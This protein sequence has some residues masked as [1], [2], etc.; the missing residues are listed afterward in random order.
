[1]I[2]KRLIQAP[3]R[4][5]PAIPIQRALL[6]SSLLQGQDTPWLGGATTSQ[7]P[8]AHCYSRTDIRRFAP[9]AARKEVAAK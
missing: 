3:S 9:S 8:V 7:D 1:M 5:D 2:C 6:L 4:G